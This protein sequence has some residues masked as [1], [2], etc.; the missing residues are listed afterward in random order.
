MSK[1]IYVVEA[2]P[3]N[4]TISISIPEN[5]TQDVA[6][7]KNMASEVLQVEHCK[8]FIIMLTGSSF[9]VAPSRVS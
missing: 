1:R 2:Q 6:G 7:N 8:D 4:D 3:D 5:V 9:F